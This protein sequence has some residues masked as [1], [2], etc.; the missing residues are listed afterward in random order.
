M[1]I[2]VGII[3]LILEIAIYIASWIFVVGL[4]TIIGLAISVVTVPC[5][6]VILFWPI[7][8]VYW[9]LK[10]LIRGKNGVK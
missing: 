10:R 6:G 3:G 8:L 5:I 7:Y 4:Y 1:D 9:A 2:I